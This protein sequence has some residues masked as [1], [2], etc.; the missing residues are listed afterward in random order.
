MPCDVTRAPRRRTQARQP[1]I[2]FDGTSS[3]RRAGRRCAS[4]T[5]SKSSSEWR[6]AVPRWA[7][8]DIRRADSPAGMLRLPA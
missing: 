1:A 6:S 8:A 2:F 3:R 5:R 7:Y 4:A